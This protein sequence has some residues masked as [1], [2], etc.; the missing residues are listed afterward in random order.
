VNDADDAAIGMLAC[1]RTTVAYCP[2]ASDYFGATRSFG[3]HRY[4]EMISAGINVALGTD[5]LVNLPT[6]AALAANGG[7]SIL[8]E[9]RYL[10]RRDHT[11]PVTLLKMGTLNGAQALGLNPWLFRFEGNGAGGHYIAGLVAV[12]TVPSTDASPPARLVM[13]SRSPPS[14]LSHKIFSGLTRNDGDRSRPIA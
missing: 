10:Y 6:A 9:M 1:T 13:E 3:P 4:R 8:D 14:L 2:R 7:M 5:S 12:E 11:D